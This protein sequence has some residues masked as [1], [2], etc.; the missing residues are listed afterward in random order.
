MIRFVV[1]NSLHATTASCFNDISREKTRQRVYQRFVDDSKTCT[2][3]GTYATVDRDFFF[4]NF[5]LIVKS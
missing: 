3:Q 1:R 2:W 5:E 4:F